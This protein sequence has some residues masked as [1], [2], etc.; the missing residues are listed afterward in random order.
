MCVRPRMVVFLVG[1][2]RCLRCIVKGRNLVGWNSA[3]AG[4]REDG[5]AG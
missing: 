2:S 5:T 1:V 4:L 3:I